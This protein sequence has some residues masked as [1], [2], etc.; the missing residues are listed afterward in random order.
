MS[1]DENLTVTVPVTFRKED[2][3][4][5]LTTA[6]EQGIG[7]WC[8]NIVRATGTRTDIAKRYVPLQDD[9]GTLRFQEYETGKLY[10]MNFDTIKKG[11]ALMAEK[12][13]KLFSEFMSEGGGADCTVADVFVQYCLFG[14]IVYG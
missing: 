2:I 6:L 4:D 13:P 10:D 3:A 9:G 14:E 5:L 12:S 11:L 8:D 7:Y 1:T